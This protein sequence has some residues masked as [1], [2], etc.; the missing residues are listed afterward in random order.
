M[1]ANPNGDQPVGRFSDRLARAIDA[2]RAP[3]CVGLDPDAGRLDPSIPG[4]VDPE[5]FTA[6]GRGVIDAVADLVPAVKP[7]SAC[8]ERFGSMGIRSLENTV[9]S[10]RDAGLLVILDAKRGDIGV[11]ARHYAAAASS[12][13]VDAITVNGYLGAETVEPYLEAGLGVFVLV[14]TSNPGSDDVQ[15]RTLAD[16]QT[17]AEMMS[18]Q[19][20][21]LGANV[22]GDRGLSDAGAVVGATKRADAVSLRRRMPHQMLLI[23]GVGAQGGTIEDVREMCRPHAERHGDLGVV[24]NASRSVIFAEPAGGEPWTEAVRRAARELAL[25][26]ASLLG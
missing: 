15:S 21:C 10:A 3:V 17:V 24:I 19:V 25:E 23:P 18:Q 4:A 12:M 8:Y 13:G 1:T 6:F 11:S 14:R 5:R 26:S 22:I 2:K 20:A 7:Q 9:R 16:G